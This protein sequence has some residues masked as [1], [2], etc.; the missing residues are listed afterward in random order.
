MNS[1]GWVC[2][3]DLGVAFNVFDQPRLGFDDAITACEEEGRTLASIR[4]LD[5][6]FGVMSVGSSLGFLETDL[7]LGV[8][9]GLDENSNELSENP[10]N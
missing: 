3:E 4:S 5:E 2:L 9:Y 6:F 7:W 8:K 10:A 1:T